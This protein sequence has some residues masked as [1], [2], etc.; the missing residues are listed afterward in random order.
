MTILD[1]AGT[2]KQADMACDALRRLVLDTEIES[3]EFL[4]SGAR[5]GYEHEMRNYRSMVANEVFW[6][7]MLEDGFDDQF[8]RDNVK[9]LQS[10]AHDCL[11]RAGAYLS[12]VHTLDES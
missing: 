10:F 8:V 4:V 2:P 9:A 6:R 5:D 11:R 1:I 12:L 7:L 3:L